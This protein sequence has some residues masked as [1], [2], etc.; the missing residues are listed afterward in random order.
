MHF[1]LCKTTIKKLTRYP[2][3]MDE[4]FACIIDHRPQKKCDARANLK[5]QG[6]VIEINTQLS[7]STLFQCPLR[8]VFPSLGMSSLFF[9]YG[10]IKIIPLASSW[11]SI[12][13]TPLLVYITYLMLQWTDCS[14]PQ[15]KSF[16]SLLA[17]VPPPSE[18]YTNTGTR[19]EV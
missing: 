6:Y 13:F 2:N 8:T 3:S 5:L 16:Q 7:H 18:I 17:Q 11:S 1:Q 10:T 12:L 14:L 19:E 15:I 4:I 9:T